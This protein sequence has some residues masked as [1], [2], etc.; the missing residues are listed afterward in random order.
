M[1]YGEF[2]KN[3]LIEGLSYGAQIQG[4]VTGDNNQIVF[5]TVEEGVLPLVVAW[6]V[7][8]FG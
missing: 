1:L 6:K 7:N 5:I 2:I 3:T 8:T 4:A